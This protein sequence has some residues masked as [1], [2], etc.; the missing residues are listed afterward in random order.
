MIQDI[1]K[2]LFP[3]SKGLAQKLQISFYRY[4][5]FSCAIWESEKIRNGKYIPYIHNET[6]L[7]RIHVTF[8][9]KSVHQAGH[10]QP[11]ELFY[12]FLNVSTENVSGRRI[13][14]SV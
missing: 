4:S 10:S 3:Y 1:P 7:K 12:L 2:A 6:T 9:L 11:T 14:P 5:T 8:N 13:K